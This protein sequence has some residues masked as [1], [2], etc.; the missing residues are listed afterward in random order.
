MV[1]VAGLGLWVDDWCHGGGVTFYSFFIHLASHLTLPFNTK[2]PVSTHSNWVWLMCQTRLPTRFWTLFIVCK[3]ES[4]FVCECYANSN[5]CSTELNWVGLILTSQA[6]NMPIQT[7]VSS[8]LLCFFYDHLSIWLDA[9]YLSWCSVPPIW[10]DYGWEFTWSV[11]LKGWYSRKCI[12][13]VACC[14]M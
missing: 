13:P 11:L 10:L 7:L 8:W 3:L 2:K 9:F 1:L 6:L 14:F 5:Q 4:Y 12:F